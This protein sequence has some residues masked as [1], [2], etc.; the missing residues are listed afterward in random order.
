MFQEGRKSIEAKETKECT[1][2]PNHK[3]KTRTERSVSLEESEAF[4]KKNMDWQEKRQ[5]TIKR[6]QCDKHSTGKDLTFAPKI[7][8]SVL[9]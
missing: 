5:V 4:F 1:F 8:S 7:V 2:S 9:K 3:T 6:Q